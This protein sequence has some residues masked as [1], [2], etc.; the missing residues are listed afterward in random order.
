M[1]YTHVYFIQHL[2]Q[3]NFKPFILNC[4]VLNFFT[5]FVSGINGCKE[6]VQWDFSQQQY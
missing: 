1:A 5:K 2:T 6:V 3:L 4:I